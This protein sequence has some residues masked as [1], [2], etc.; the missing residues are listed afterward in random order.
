VS[1]KL[2]DGLII[3]EEWKNLGL[4]SHL[5]QRRRFRQAFWVR[6]WSVCNKLEVLPLRL[7]NL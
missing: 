4:G 7:V 2:A 6:Q 1:V 3:C 5:L